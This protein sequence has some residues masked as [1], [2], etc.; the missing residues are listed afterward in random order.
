MRSSVRY[1]V[2][3]LTPLLFKRITTFK[4]L[5]EE[6]AYCVY[7]YKVKSGISFRH[8]L[9]MCM[10]GSSARYVVKFLAPPL[11]MPLCKRI[12]TFKGTPCKGSIFAFTFTHPRQVVAL[13]YKNKTGGQIGFGTYLVERSVLMRKL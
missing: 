10:M 11:S 2:S 12:T 13:L 9:E 8:V 3:F 5:P 6:E 4:E 1:V 7:I